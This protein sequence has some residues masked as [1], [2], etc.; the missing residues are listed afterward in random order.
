MNSKLSTYILYQVSGYSSKYISVVEIICYDSKI[1]VPQSLHRRVLD[2]YHFY[3]I[4]QLVV[5]LQKQ[6]DSYVIGK[7]LMLNDICMLSH[8]IYFNGSKIERLFLDIG[9]QR[10]L[11]RKTRGLLHVDL[12]GTY[13]KYTIQQQSGRAIIINN[14]SLTCMTIIDSATGW[15]I[16]IEITTCNLD[17]VTG[18]NGEYIDKS[19]TRVIYLFNNTCLS[20]YPC[21]HKKLFDNGS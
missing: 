1:Y 21:P 12:I 14:I 13:S 10:T 20:R 11:Q 8:A 7:A 18:G 17:E 15:F 6:F 3:F 2:W 5:D 9:H 16:I 19:S 4:N